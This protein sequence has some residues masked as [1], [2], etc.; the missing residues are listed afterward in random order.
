MIAAS[1]DEDESDMSSDGGFPDI[2]AAF[3]LPK[4]NER[5]PQSLFETPRAKRTMHMQAVHVSPLTLNPKPRHMFD[6]KALARDAKRDDATNA[7]SL[8]LQETAAATKKADTEA[9]LSRTEGSGSNFADFIQVK[10]GKNAH[11]VMRAVQR[12]EDASRLRFCF[13]DL[14]YQSPP[15]TAIAKSSGPWKLLTHANEQAREQFLVSGVP[16]TILQKSGGLPD[17][18]FIWILDELCIQHST[19]VL[20]EFSNLIASCPD[21]IEKLVT[22]QRLEQLFLRLGASEAEI[23][24]RDRELPTFKPA[25]EPYKDRDWSNLRVFLDLLAVM[26]HQLTIPST[27]SS[28]QVLLRMAVDKF[29]VCNIDVLVSYQNA[30]QCLLEAIPYASWN[31]FVRIPCTPFLLHRCHL[32]TA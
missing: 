32:L 7:S 8:R 17:E 15:P 23:R 21:Q 13:F 20:E 5:P 30:M 29:L 10:S 6:L 12:T 28:V 19:L 2:M 25:D 16:Y 11:K 3:N 22:S 18:I 31:S 1:D 27:I 14:N 9:A 24:V 26:S 4:A